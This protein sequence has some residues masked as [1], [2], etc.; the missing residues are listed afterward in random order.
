MPL[1]YI[2]ASGKREEDYNS[3]FRAILNLEPAINPTDIVTDFEMA[4]INAVR[5]NFPLA[6]PHG[7][8]FHFSQNIWRHIQ[9]VGLQSIHN[10]DAE[11]AFQL[12]LLIA[13]AFL[14]SGSIVEA[15]EEL[16]ATEF[17][18]GPN[19]HKDA[20]E[21]LLTYFQKTYVFAFDRL[22][23]RMAPLFPPELWSVY[24]VMLSGK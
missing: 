7:C 23:K 24:N 4:A 6:E 12:R 10:E 20:I 8:F 9:K 16:V 19:E 17:Y 2:L 13:L 18:D 1:V 15:Y 11:F 5:T 21:Q 22:G 3:I 14:P